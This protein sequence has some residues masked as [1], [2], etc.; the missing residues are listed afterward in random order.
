M[1]HF[2]KL[3]ENNIVVEVLV[4]RDEDENNE[5]ELSE[6][7]GETYKRTSYNTYKN[8]HLLGGI[9]F[10]G[11]FAGIGMTYLPLENIFIPTKCHAEAV[12]NAASA[13][14]DCTNI[15]HESM[16]NEA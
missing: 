8:T 2:A 16:F 9:P 7:T 11:N 4:G 1:A 12:L 5:L 6:R 14:W 13:K 10:R 15:D 3:D